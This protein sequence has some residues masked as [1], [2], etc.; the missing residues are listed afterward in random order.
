MLGMQPQPQHKER[1]KSILNS[2]DLQKI[3]A[4]GESDL[5]L[6]IRYFHHDFGKEDMLS[7]IELLRQNRLICLNFLDSL[8]MN[9]MGNE[10]SAAFMEALKINSSLVRLDINMV[11]FDDERAVKLA[12]ALK[13]NNCLQE[14]YLGSNKIGKK[15][16]IAL[17]DMLKTNRSL[18]KLGITYDKNYSGVAVVKLAEALEM[19]NCLQE[20]SFGSNNLG[21]RGR[22]IIG[23]TGA[24]ALAKA[25]ET[26]RSVRSL[27]IDDAGIGEKGI[28][29]LAS[30][31]TLNSSL[32]ELYL[33]SN[34]IGKK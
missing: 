22:N 8:Q 14:L 29:A 1:N 24:V 7:L 2:S 34:P 26:N 15:G 13:I 21:R 10:E 27:S 19:N 16:A 32:Q 4:G 33:A 12:E 6:D 18:L 28:V 3:I 20:L 31:L 30:M 25:L 23:E 9:L 17:A 5:R 11:D